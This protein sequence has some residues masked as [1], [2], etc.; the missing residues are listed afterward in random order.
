MFV[1]QALSLTVTPVKMALRLQR[2]F[3]G[4]EKNLLALKIIGSSDTRLQ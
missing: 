3:F 2:Q 1:I 4:P